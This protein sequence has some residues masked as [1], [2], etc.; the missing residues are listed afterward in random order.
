MGVEVVQRGDGDQ[1]IEQEDGDG[2]GHN[3]YG[4]RQG[5]RCCRM[6]MGRTGS[7]WEHR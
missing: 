4:G 2:L 7:R 6:Q 1:E 5:C 3:V